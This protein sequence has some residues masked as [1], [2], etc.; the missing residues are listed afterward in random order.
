[1]IVIVDIF[2]DIVSR[3]SQKMGYEINYLFG[4]WSQ[5]AKEM[6]ILSKYNITEQN[7]YPLI[8][9]FTPFNEDK[10]SPDYYCT[11]SLSFMIATRTLSDYTNEQ[12]L[13]ISY[14]EILHPVY[15][16][17]ITEIKKD[18]KFDFGYTPFVKHSY[19]DNMRYGSRGVYGSDGKRPFSDL[20][21]GVDISNLEVKVRKEQICR[22]K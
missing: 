6:D 10:S 11:A 14:K 2:R 17:F 13:E 15:E 12:R 5:I 22:K 19:S 4:E 1:M 8:S 20:F 21:D 9:L 3:T 16:A 18:K 7:K